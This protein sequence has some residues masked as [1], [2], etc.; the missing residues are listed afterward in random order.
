MMDR[1]YSGALVTIV[2]APDNTK[3]GNMD[4]GLKGVPRHN[5]V[6]S[7]DNEGTKREIIQPSAEVRDEIGRAH[8]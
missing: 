2:A 7:S 3:E 6:T 8:V 5:F 1:V 4:P